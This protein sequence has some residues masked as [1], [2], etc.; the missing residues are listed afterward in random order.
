MDVNTAYL[1]GFINNDIYIKISKGFKLFEENN[2]KL[3]S[4]SSIKL[5]RF[6][7]ALKL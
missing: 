3:R 1:Y 2:T 6:L 7:Y 5:Q 4:M